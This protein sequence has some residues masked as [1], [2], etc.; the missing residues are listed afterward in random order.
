MDSPSFA[1]GMTSNAGLQ[2]LPDDSGPIKM[3]EHVVDYVPTVQKISE[4][5][6]RLRTAFSGDALFMDKAGLDL[7]AAGL[8]RRRRQ[9]DGVCSLQ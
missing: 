1:Y 2:R 8:L 9:R 5:A 3:T 6:A 4:R 7:Q